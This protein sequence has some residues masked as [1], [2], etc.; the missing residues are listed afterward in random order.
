MTNHVHLLPQPYKEVSK[1]LLLIKK[2]SG[3][4][5]SYFN[6]L[7]GRSGT[8]WKGRYKSSSVKS[9]AYLLAC[10]RYIELNPVRAGITD[11]PAGY[12]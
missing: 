9:D 12:A 2:L 11:N 7:E 4:A 1:I 10:T 5:T 3:R 8:L 6:L